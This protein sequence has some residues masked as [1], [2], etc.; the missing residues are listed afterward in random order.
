MNKPLDSR[1]L[2]LILDPKRFQDLNSGIDKFQQIVKSEMEALGG[3]FEKEKDTKLKHRRTW[4]LDTENFELKS[5]N[6]FFRIRKVEEKEDN[7]YDITLKCRHEDRYISADYDLTSSIKKQY[8][9]KF[10]EDI[11]APYVSK[12]SIS[13]QYKDK[14]KPDI[15]TIGELK[16]IFPGLH[17]HGLKEGILKKVNGF[18]AKEISC[19]I[20]KILF[21][22]NSEE[23]NQIRTDLNFWYLPNDERIPLIV[24]F[25]FDYNAKKIKNAK[26]IDKLLMEEFPLSLVQSSYK[27]YRA[28]QETRIVDLESSKTK[29]SFA[30]DYKQ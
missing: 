11:I 10:E 7:E 2:K 28:L 30:Y 15:N 1:E 24:E 19:E 9:I 3:T 17:N 5:K 13:A 20:G 29:T 16:S 14:E 18:E 27:F 4:Y 22:G 23:D 26:D 12:F 25:T 21:D 6:F 8:E